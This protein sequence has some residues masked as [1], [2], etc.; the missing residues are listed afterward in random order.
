MGRDVVWEHGDNL[1]FGFKCMYCVNEFHGGGA[2]RLK[3]YLAGKSGNIAR[4]TKCPPDIRDYFLCE[5]QKVR[6][7]KKVINDER[8]HRVQCIILKPDDEDEELQ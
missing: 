7:R 8:L 5:L 6:E 4:C 1:F 3:E 2:T